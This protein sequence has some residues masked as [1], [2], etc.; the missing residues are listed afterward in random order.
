MK[1]FVTK[2]LVQGQSLGASFVSDVLPFQHI[3]SP[4]LQVVVSGASSL[5][6]AFTVEGTSDINP[7]TGQ[8]QN[9]VALTEFTSMSVT[10]D[11][12]KYWF[13]KDSMLSMEYIRIS[14]ARTGGTGSVTVI[15][16]GVRI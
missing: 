3:Y 2:R 11:G 16:S 15:A 14:Y 10:A 7:G 5:N 4:F 12:V 8:P 9:W 1:Q 13:L 6:G